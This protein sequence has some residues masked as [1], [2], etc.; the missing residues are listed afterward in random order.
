VH[1]KQSQHHTE[2]FNAA[3]EVTAHVARM[4]LPMVP[5]CESTSIFMFEYLLKRQ[6]TLWSIIGTVHCLQAAAGRS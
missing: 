5:V 6:L 3:R 4:M 1:A 2:W